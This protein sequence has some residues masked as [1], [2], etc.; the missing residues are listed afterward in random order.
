MVGT[1]WYVVLTSIL[2]VGQFYVE[3][4]FSR[5]APRALPPTPFGGSGRPCGAVGVVR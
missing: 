4:H 2:S 1:A 5:G 3:R